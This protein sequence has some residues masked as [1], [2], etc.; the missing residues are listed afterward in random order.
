VTALAGWVSDR[1]TVE[2]EHACSTMLRALEGYSRREAV[3]A[4][5][6]I[7]A[8]GA[9]LFPTL[10]EDEFDVQPIAMA[11]KLLIADIRLDNRPDLLAALGMEA[12]EA[13]GLADSAVLARAWLKWGEDSLQR[14]VGDFAIAIYEG[15]KRKLTLAR[16]PTGQRPLFYAENAGGIAFASMPSGLLALECNRR[17]FDHH[18]LAQVLADVRPQPEASYFNG[19]HR[20]PAGH[21]LTWTDG[22]IATHRYWQPSRTPLVLSRQDDYVAAYRDVLSSAV[23]SR[24]RT[25]SPVLGTQL[26]SGYDSSAVT[27]TAALLRQPDDHLIAFTSAPRNG[28]FAPLPRGRIADESPIA[29]RTAAMHGIDHI[30]LRSAGSIFSHIASEAGTYQEPF[31]NIINNGWSVVLEEEAA[32]RGASVMLAGDLGNLTLHFGSLEILADMLTAG[33]W[34]EWWREA[35][36]ARRSGAVRWRGVIMNSF[37]PWLPAFVRTA[38]LRLFNQPKHGP[39]FGFVRPQWRDRILSHLPEGHRPIGDTFTDRWNGLSEFDFGTIRKGTLGSTGIDIRDVMSDRRLI[40]FSLNLPREQ[41]FASGHARPLARRALSDRLPPEVINSTV[42]GM[43]AADWYEHADLSELRALIEVAS[44]SPIANELI[45]FDRLRL[46]VEEWPTEGF[47]RMDVIQ[48]FVG[49]VPTTVATA[50]FIQ[51]F[52][53]MAGTA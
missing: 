35:R 1:I 45:D 19:V 46:A 53:R 14:I 18:V 4:V 40:Q 37:E 49:A 28:F 47:E 32:A 29:A 10:P 20:V 50:L 34:G 43:Q 44:S 38:L 7:A 8:L 16:D 31:R 33:E 12:S 5:S 13:R 9:A 51:H 21:V 25:R 41:L 52:E 26:S 48:K 6:S 27:A 17:G 39:D 24:M 11:D 15:A 42:R 22:A 23:K 30:V 2:P 3:V 36:L